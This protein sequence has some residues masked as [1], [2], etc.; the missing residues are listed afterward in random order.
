MSHE[1]PLATSAA[2]ALERPEKAALTRADAEALAGDMIV[3]SLETEWI[4]PKDGD[5]IAIMDKA[6]AGPGKGYVQ[7]Y[8]DAK[9]AP[10]LAVTYWKLVK[11]KKAKAKPKPKAKQAAA[12]KPAEDHTD[13]LYFR[14]GRTKKSRRRVYVD[15]RQMDLFLENKAET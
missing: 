15:P 3:A 9:G 12:P 5:V 11:P 8:E 7:R 2:D 13:D 1:Y 10:V 14:S 6:D 4:T